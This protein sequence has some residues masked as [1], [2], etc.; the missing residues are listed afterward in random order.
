V[1]SETQNP[2]IAG[3]RLQE[4]AERLAK[5]HAE[6]EHQGGAGADQ[7]FYLRGIR[8]IGVDTIAAQIGIGKRTL[9]PIAFKG[10]DLGP[11]R[12]PRHQSCPQ[13]SRP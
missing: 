10:A 13:T 12:V 6:A 4:N 2:N 11:S 9:Y 3:Q 1:N 8:A 5:P 7:L